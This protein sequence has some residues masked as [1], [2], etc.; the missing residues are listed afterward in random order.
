MW[1]S[2]KVLVVDDD[3]VVGRSINRVLSAKGYE[4]REAL[5]GEE[6][7]EE[8]DHRE[9]D[10]VF[11]DV[12]MPGIDGMEMTSRLKQRHPEVPV[13]IITGYG[14]EAGERQARDLGVTGYL[15]KPLTPEMIIGN[16]ERALRERQETLEAIRR[17]ALT[18]LQPAPAAE[19]AA[20]VP[21]PEAR[22]AA[23]V[24]KNIGLFFAAP[25]I[26]LAYVLAFPFVGLWAIVK[27]GYQALTRRS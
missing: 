5:S 21:V 20:A 7:L 15:R 22:G 10:L 3:A 9:Y 24:A 8:L 14:T 4:V 18:M 25:F 6:A 1:Q 2:R 23:N 12:R 13:V 27:Y 16:A 11:T 17:S 19:T 26:G